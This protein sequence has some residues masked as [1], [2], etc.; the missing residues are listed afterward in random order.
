MQYQTVDYAETEEHRMIRETARRYL[1]DKLAPIAADI[2]REERFPLEVFKG[3]GALGL[4]GLIAPEAY[5]GGGHDVL[6]T[7]IVAEEIA[8]ICAGTYTSTTGHVFCTHWI[9]KYGTPEQKAKYLPKLT[10]TEWIGGMAITEPEAG[11]DVASLKTRAVRQGDHWVVNGTK[12]FITNGSVANVI[13]CLTRTGGPGPKG[14]S[15]LIIETATPGFSA[16]K[17][18][19]KCGNRASPTCEITF[20]NCRVPVENLLGKENNGFVESMV[21]FPFERALVGVCCGALC[22]SALLAA[23]AYCKERKQFGKPLIEFQMVQQ[24]LAD[25][26]VD[27]HVT[28][29]LTRD[30]LKKYASGADANVEASITKIFAADAALRVTSQA[31]Q[32][33]GGYGYTREFPVERWF[34]DARLFSIGGGT[35]QIQKLIVARALM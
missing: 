17:P 30:A 9:D 6:G 22:E 11:S 1:A 5:G 19:E 31:V 8:R 33:L 18:F 3:L 27:L 26:A 35:S 29:T 32:L 4:L 14:I 16:S 15:T 12:T 20:E 34:R 13:V 24:M 10:S 7:A 25:M 21:F 2:D 23:L 28:K